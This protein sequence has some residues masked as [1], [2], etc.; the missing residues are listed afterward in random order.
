MVVGGDGSEDGA[1]FNFSYNGQLIRIVK[2]TRYLGVIFNNNLTWGDQFKSTVKRAKKA[3]HTV[4]EVCCNHYLDLDLRV[5]IWHTKVLTSLLYGCEVWN[6]TKT[7]YSKLKAF[8]RDC[9]RKMLG[10][11][12]Y[13]SFPKAGLHG[14]LGIARIPTLVLQRKLRF[15]H[16]V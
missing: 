7:Q 14:L 2:S 12:N 8:Q 6:L 16:R 5:E 15:Y 11:Q 1:N 13:K 10:V 3:W 9:M 4:A